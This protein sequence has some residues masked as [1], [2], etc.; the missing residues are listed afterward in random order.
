[1]QCVTRT[2]HEAVIGWM[3]MRE[4]DNGRP[5]RMGCAVSNMHFRQLL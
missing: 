3:S 2:R 5:T 4:G 1:M